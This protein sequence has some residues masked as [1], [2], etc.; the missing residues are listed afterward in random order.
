M[1]RSS[2][3]SS[4]IAMAVHYRTGCHFRIITI[5]PL[6]CLYLALNPI[7]EHKWV[8]QECKSDCSTI[9]KLVAPPIADSNRHTQEETTKLLNQ[10]SENASEYTNS[11][12]PSVFQHVKLECRNRYHGSCSN[13]MNERIAHH[14]CIQ[15][16]CLIVDV[17]GGP[18][19]RID[20]QR[21][22][23]HKQ[24]SRLHAK[25]PKLLEEFLHFFLCRCRIYPILQPRRHKLQPGLALDYQR[26]SFP[27]VPQG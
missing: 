18:P 4:S 5:L 13:K 7:V 16:L 23:F 1:N 14:R 2:N 24:R 17:N 6:T 10:H 3:A 19:A 20:L 26:K 8:L 12:D 22:R 25:Q 27:Q 21:G 11:Y 9:R 15:G